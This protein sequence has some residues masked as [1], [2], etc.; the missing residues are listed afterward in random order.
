[1]DTLTKNNPKDVVS[2]ILC[3]K[4]SFD[5]CIVRERELWHVHVINELTVRSKQK[6][7]K[8]SVL[9]SVWNTDMFMYSM[10]SLIKTDPK[11]AININF[12]SEKELADQCNMVIS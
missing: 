6:P 4:E 5:M 12:L 10:H 3:L 8:Q 7:E 9:S 1:M 11:E 2:L